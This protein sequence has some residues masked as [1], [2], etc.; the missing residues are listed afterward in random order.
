[1]SHVS[2]W[3]RRTG[4][5][6]RDVLLARHSFQRGLETGEIVR[7]QINEHS[8]LNQNRGLRFEL[9]SVKVNPFFGCLVMTHRFIQAN[10]RRG[11]CGEIELS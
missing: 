10:T 11:A 1:M 6:C 2:T 8:K 3:G 7:L 4:G 5:L 9:H